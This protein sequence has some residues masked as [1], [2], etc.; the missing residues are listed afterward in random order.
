[1]CVC[2]DSMA[3]ENPSMMDRCEEI[4]PWHNRYYLIRL[5]SKQS[6]QYFNGRADSSKN[7]GE[8]YWMQFLEKADEE[9][10]FIVKTGDGCV[11]ADEIIMELDSPIDDLTSS[12]RSGKL[13]FSLQ[14]QLVPYQDTLH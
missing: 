12:Y 3:E 8:L 13:T 4:V 11:A 9:G 5:M 10:K 1:M 2:E 6:M 14:Q 7:G